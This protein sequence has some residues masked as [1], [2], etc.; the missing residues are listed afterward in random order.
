M[1]F[2]KLSVHGKNKNYK[3]ENFFSKVNVEKHVFDMHMQK[4]VYEHACMHKFGCVC[5]RVGD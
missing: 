5:K 2:A 1:Q 4:L 3:G